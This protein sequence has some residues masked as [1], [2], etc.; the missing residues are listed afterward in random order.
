MPYLDAVPVP[1]PFTG[2]SSRSR[3]ASLRGAQVATVK[4]GSQASRMLAY[5][6]KYGPQTDSSMAPRFGP[7]FP[8]ARVSARRAGLMKRGWVREA[9]A[10]LGSHGVTVCLWWLTVA[11]QRVAEKLI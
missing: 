4:A 9:G 8:E 3:Q 1:L 10:T 11:G 2:K 6:A 5:Y 7:T